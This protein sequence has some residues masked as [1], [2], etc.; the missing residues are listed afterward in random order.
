M[1]KTWCVRQ[2]KGHK[3][4]KVESPGLGDWLDEKQEAGITEFPAFWFGQRRGWWSL[5]ERVTG[6]SAGFWGG[7]GADNIKYKFTCLDLLD[8]RCLWNI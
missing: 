5:T 4:C 6:Q 2:P 7:W 3:E 1:I 8:L